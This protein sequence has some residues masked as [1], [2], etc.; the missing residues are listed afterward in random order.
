[1]PLLYFIA[2][3]SDNIDRAELRSLGLG[4]AFEPSGPLSKRGCTRGPGGKE[5]VVV[6]GA[7]TDEPVGFFK[8]SQ[9][10]QKIP[11]LADGAEAYV[12][13]YTETPISP[14][15]LLRPDALE[16]HDVQLGD[17]QRWHVPV[18]LGCAEE[19]GQLQRYTPLPR[20]L[21]LDDEGKFTP[22]DPLPQYDALWSAAWGY[23]EAV[24][25]AL[26]GAKAG[27]TARFALDDEWA[28]AALATNYRIGRAEIVLLGLLTWG[29]TML[30]QILDAV[31]AVPGAEKLKKKQDSAGSASPAG[32][33]AE[34]EDTG[35]QSPT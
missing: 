22:G 15:E 19:E 16:G 10:W 5:G 3:R 32:Q 20:R 33:P 9:R 35:P 7:A 28:V 17:G 30:Q 29:G 18:A 2:E 26:A 13:R 11:A 24:E 27:E 12:G 25:E 21:Q 23:L 31:V 14:A 34:T 8:D 6:C 4:Y 1:M